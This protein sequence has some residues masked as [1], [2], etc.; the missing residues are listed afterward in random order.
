MNTRGEYNS[1]RAMI[2][3]CEDPD[4]PSWKYYGGRG[5]RVCARWRYSFPSFLMDMGMR[6]STRHSLDRINPDLG[7]G[8]ANCRWATPDVQARNKRVVELTGQRFGRLVVLH[9]TRA[10]RD[11]RARWVCQCACGRQTTVDGHSLRRGNTQ[12]CGC[13]ARDNARERMVRLKRK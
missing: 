13:L 9:R 10:G 4:H 1:W 3:R 12:S 7:Y 6:P 5:I 8:P 11:G 2:A